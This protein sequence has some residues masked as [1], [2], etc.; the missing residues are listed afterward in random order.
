MDSPAKLSTHTTTGHP[1]PADDLPIDENGRLVGIH[2]WRCNTDLTGRAVGDACPTCAYNVFSSVQDSV[3]AAYSL[4]ISDFRMPATGA[5]CVGC[6]ALI[7]T[8]RYGATCP[9]CDLSVAV[10]GEAHRLVAGAGAID[11]D[12]NCLNCGYNLR[13]LQGAARCPECGSQ[14]VLSLFRSELLIADPGWLRGIGI[15]SATVAATS[16]IA[17]LLAFSFSAI[18]R[19]SVEAILLGATAVV[20]IIGL[21]AMCRPEPRSSAPANKRVRRTAGLTALSLSL[22]LALLIGTWIGFVTWT[23]I[24]IAGLIAVIAAIA[25]FIFCNTTHMRAL[26]DRAGDKTLA[27]SFAM[28]RGFFIVWVVLVTIPLLLGVLWSP[29]A[30]EPGNIV[31]VSFCAGPIGGLSLYGLSVVSQISLASTYFRAARTSRAALRAVPEAET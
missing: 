27:D 3:Y 9:K 7:D 21:Y 17:P 5:K 4:P 2:C 22:A 25:V 31:M 14:I 29:I 18:A 1:P 20:Y 28:I 11:S 26:A 24:P 6:A 12:T 16:I 13:A 30:G 19:T 23:T 10:S 8:L 15:A